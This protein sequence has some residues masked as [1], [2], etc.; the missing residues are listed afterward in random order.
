M[1]KPLAI[2][3]PMKLPAASGIG[4]MLKKPLPKSWPD[5]KFSENTTNTRP[6]KPWATRLGMDLLLCIFFSKL[7]TR[8]YALGN[9]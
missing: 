4:G 8:F 2:K 9:S 1:K 7:G 6:I 3:A 5:Q